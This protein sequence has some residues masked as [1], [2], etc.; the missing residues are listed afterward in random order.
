MSFN[1]ND[2]SGGGSGGKKVTLT[3]GAYPG[4]LVGVVLLGKQP[5]KP[6]QGQEKDPAYEVGFTYEFLDEFMLD[7]DDQEDK[8]KPRWLT[9][10]MPL[11]GL[12]AEK[13]KSTKRYRAMDP[14]NKHGGDLSKLLDT[15]VLITVTNSPKKDGSG[16]WE[17]I[18]S[19][20][21]M[22]DK[23]AAKA[24]PLVNKAFAFD[25]ADPDME[26]FHK[27]PKFMRDK[28][29]ANLEFKGSKLEA[30][31]KE[32]GSDSPGKS[33]TTEPPKDQPADEEGA[34]NPY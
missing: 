3:P 2:Y 14:A 23:D 7:D 25:P 19:V 27:L 11:Y 20:S 33:D 24:G 8:S 21:L 6:Y 5:Q 16:V 12:D 13:A 34:D 29:T 15:P 1:V 31:L 4:R 30:A 22:R 26:V 9:E 32:V 17:N 28:I 10:F 18:D